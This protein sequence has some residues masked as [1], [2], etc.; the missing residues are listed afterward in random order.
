MSGG[1]SQ[2][3]RTI[4]TERTGFVQYFWQVRH[5]FETATKSLQ[6]VLVWRC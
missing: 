6:N 4:P 3:I 1:F 2:E 5:D